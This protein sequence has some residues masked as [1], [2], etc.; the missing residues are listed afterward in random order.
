MPVVKVDPIILFA[1][2]QHLYAEGP[3]YL[4]SDAII[5]PHYYLIMKFISDK[6]GLIKLLPK[7]FEW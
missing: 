2:S 7:S 5:Y 4:L 6:E 1:Q 3:E